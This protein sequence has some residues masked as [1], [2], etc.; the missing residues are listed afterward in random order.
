MQ[1]QHRFV[2]VCRPEELRQN[3]NY[4]SSSSLNKNN[5]RKSASEQDLGSHIVVVSSYEN[6]QTHGLTVKNSSASHNKISEDDSNLRHYHQP[7]ASSPIDDEC[8][9]DNA[10]NH[11]IVT[12]ASSPDLAYKSSSD[13]GRGTRTSESGSAEVRDSASVSPPLDIT[14]LDSDQTDSHR[15]DKPQQCNPNPS[16]GQS[17][18]ITLDKMQ[19]DLKKILE[20]D[21]ELTS[22]GGGININTGLS[23]SL[24]KNQC[25]RL[26]VV[27]ES[28]SW[29][30]D[31]SKTVDEPEKSSSKKIESNSGKKKDP[32][33]LS[34]QQSIKGSLTTNRN[35]LMNGRGEIS[36]NIN[37]NGL[38]SKKLQP[39]EKSLPSKL[40]VNN[41][42]TTDISSTNNPI[43]GQN[44]TP[45]KPKLGQTHLSN[46]KYGGIGKGLKL[47]TNKRW[48]HPLAE[49]TGSVTTLG[50]ESVDDVDDLTSEYTANTDA[51][52]NHENTHVRKQLSGL[53][54]MYSEILNLLGSRMHGAKKSMHHSSSGK[55]NRRL[56]GSVSSLSVAS[57]DA[58]YSRNNKYLNRR[59]DFDSKGAR[60]LKR[61]EGHVITLARSV[62]QLSSEI[63]SSQ[64]FD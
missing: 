27:H 26:P 19:A 44:K 15:S 64:C 53:E 42:M 58:F 29:I 11:M 28:D 2:E 4:V 3:D 14:S 16:T 63:R 1:S 56:S 17:S 5:D 52:E 25:S 51:W 54:N 9:T 59:D 12:S 47:T 60:R 21:D 45:N 39:T 49:E 48:R 10:L 24:L 46:V 61:L 38:L 36:G 30:S 18:V 40:N 6:N 41:T 23:L 20:D 34:Q 22:D 32:P 43:T 62:S 13:S 33:T 7:E 35:L 50:L 8:K 55:L 31:S 37:K 57:R